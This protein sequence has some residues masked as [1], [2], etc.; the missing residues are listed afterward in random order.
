MKAVVCHR[1]ELA[2]EQIPEPQPEQGQSLLQ[3]HRCGICGSDLHARHH[4]NTLAD[5][6]ATAGLDGMMRYEQK[7]VMGHE[8]CGE[9][10]EHGPGTKTRIKP[11]TRVCALPMLQHAGQMELLGFSE[12]V[13][14]AYAERVLV[15]D[16]HMVPIP[17]GLGVDV[18]ALTE[19]M[20]IGLHAVNRAEINTRDVAIVIGCGPVGLA[21]ICNLKSRG[22]RHIIA[23]DFSP[24][25]RK[26]AAQCGAHEV[27][28][29]AENT[30]W[31]SWSDFGFNQRTDAM[32]EQAVDALR[33]M[34]K[35]PVPWW[36]QWRLADALGITAPKR[37][38]VF[39]CVGVPG[40]IQQLITE[41]PLHSRIVVVGVCMETDTLQPS[42]A[43]NK[44]IDLRFVLGYSPLEYRDT[45]HSLANGKLTASPLI[46]GTV[47]LN[48]VEQAFDALAD[49]ESHIKILVDPASDDMPPGS[50]V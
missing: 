43:I 11:G 17:N 48:G 6:S 15:N 20:A 47:G 12:R 27:I 18:A 30:P 1:G 41:G 38:V 16:V 44:E 32:L 9:V 14:G 50:Q 25:R 10:L 8:F 26:M 23:S 42:L 4:C 31:E 29:P 49:P 5:A 19:P 34:Q 46:T 28:D 2:V 39:E 37:P 35:L 24:K 22:V 3:V 13:N 21:V 33:K 45:L 36:H 7:V 40:I